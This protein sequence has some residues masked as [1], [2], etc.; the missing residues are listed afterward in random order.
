M[1]EK[2]RDFVCDAQDW[3]VFYVM[4]ATAGLSLTILTGIVTTII[5]A[6]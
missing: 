4:F 1:L 2:F 5:K 3:A 6:F